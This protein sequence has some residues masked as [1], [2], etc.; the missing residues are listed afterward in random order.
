MVMA[1]PLRFV[2]PG[3]V[4]HVMARGDGGKPVFISRQDH[5]LF[6]HWLGRVCESHGWLIHAWVLMGNHFHLLLETPEPNLV[7]GMKLLLG[8]YGQA[9]NRLHQR[10][11]H[12][13]QGRYKSIPV[14]GERAS[15]PSQFRVVADYIHLNPARAG[16]AGGKHGKLPAYEWSSLPAYQRGQGPEWLVFDRVLA[17]FDLAGNRR[18]R[19]AYVD[20]LQQRAELD[21]GNLPDAAMAALRRGWYLGDEKFRARLLSLVGK[22]AKSL[23]KKGSHAP[24]PVRGHGEM[25][26]E[27]IVADGLK[28]LGLAGVSDLSAKTR[29][30][31]PRKVALATLVKSRTCVGNEWLARR[32]VMGHNRSVSRLIR[33]GRDKPAVQKSCEILEK[34]LPCED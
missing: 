22:G 2:Y 1:R 16:L 14:A 10:R 29:K 24:A 19:R 5:L 27:K 7:S 17:A 23:R 9:W 28:I 4:Y 3:A 6:L 30:G 31:E 25:E 33:Q 11:G 15:D 13:F 34:M 26:A 20:Y 12:V 32:L 21:G 18:G 8:S